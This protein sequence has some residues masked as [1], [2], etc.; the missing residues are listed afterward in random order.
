MQI[1]WCS[2]PREFRLYMDFD[3]LTGPSEC[4]SPYTAWIL[5]LDVLLLMD[6]LINGMLA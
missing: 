1:V 4:Q 6:M 3:I 5:G 2:I